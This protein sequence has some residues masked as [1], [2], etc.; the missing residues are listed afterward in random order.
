MAH[1]IV[2]DDEDDGGLLEATRSRILGSWVGVRLFRFCDIGWL[3][4][5]GRL[6]AWGWGV[7]RSDRL[8]PTVHPEPAPPLVN[9]V[10]QSAGF[11]TLT[12][13]RCNSRPFISGILACPRAPL[14]FPPHIYISIPGSPLS[15]ALEPPPHPQARRPGPAHAGPAHA[16]ARMVSSKTA[17]V[18][19]LTNGDLIM[20]GV[21]PRMK[22]LAPC[23]AHSFLEQSI[24]LVYFCRPSAR[25][26]GNPSV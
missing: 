18:A 10:R 2:K 22:P 21:N 16:I 26:D 25:C 24:A 15:S 5:R 7:W 1:H 14:P 3:E 11:A 13:Y 23:S 6:P 9:P 17:K 12:K 19:P 20:V 8:F 4:V